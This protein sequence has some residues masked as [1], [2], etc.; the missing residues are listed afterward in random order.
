MSDGMTDA[1]RGRPVY[2]PGWKHKP[3]KSDNPAA[4]SQPPPKRNEGPAILP[5]VM[6]DL[7]ARSE[8]GRRKYGTA[9]EA[10]NGRDALMD[11]YQEALDLAM[12][13]RQAIAERDGA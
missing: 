3:D 6:I 1:A 13:L 10:N 2:S 8:M 12:Y 9:L 7:A 5:L 4:S 11:A